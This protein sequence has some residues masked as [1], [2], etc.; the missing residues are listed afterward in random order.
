MSVS[1]PTPLAQKRASISAD[2]LI[3]YLGVAALA[4]SCLMMIFSAPPVTSQTGDD[5]VA[6]AFSEAPAN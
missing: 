5:Q 3:L 2:W 6:A 4:V 1:V